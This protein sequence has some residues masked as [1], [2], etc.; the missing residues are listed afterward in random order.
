MVWWTRPEDYASMTTW[1]LLKKTCCCTTRNIEES[2]LCWTKSLADWR[3]FSRHWIGPCND[4]VFSWEVRL[5][6]RTFWR[7]RFHVLLGNPAGRSVDSDFKQQP[8]LTGGPERPV[9]YFLCDY[10][11]PGVRLVSQWQYVHSHSLFLSKIPVRTGDGL[12]TSALTTS[13]HVM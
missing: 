6:F 7:Q 12:Y 4:R 9:G 5:I 11:Q 2:D 13:S 1:L 10:Q 8:G 3:C